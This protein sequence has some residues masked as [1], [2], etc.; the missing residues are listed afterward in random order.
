MWVEP[1]NY[2]NLWLCRCVPS[3]NVYIEIPVFAP[4]EIQSEH[5]PFFREKWG[6]ICFF[7]ANL[8]G[9]WFH[10][11]FMCTL[12]LGRIP[13]L[14]SMFNHELVKTSFPLTK[15]DVFLT[16]IFQSYLL[17]LGSFGY[18]K[19]LGFKFS[20]K[21]VWVFG[22]LGSGFGRK[23]YRVNWRRKSS[24]DDDQFAVFVHEEF[25]LDPVFPPTSLNLTARK[26]YS[27]KQTHTKWDLRGIRRG[28]PLDS[29]QTNHYKYCKWCIVTLPSYRVLRNPTNH[30]NPDAPYGLFT[31]IRSLG[32]KKCHIQLEM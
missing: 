19:F 29:H 6:C 2:A 27:K 25:C 18:S 3:W 5:E 16:L 14:A 9:W 31:Y 1:S 30:H 8:T 24:D 26:L 7:K 12:K 11:C 4:V 32:E 17:R 22:S 21:N 23:L 13:I 15:R 20:P 10:I 28:G